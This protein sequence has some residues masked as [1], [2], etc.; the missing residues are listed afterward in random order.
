MQG[1]VG[2]LFQFKIKEAIK[3]VRIEA[4]K[5]YTRYAE[6]P[7]TSQRRW[8]FDME[9]ELLQVAKLLHPVTEGIYPQ[10]QFFSSL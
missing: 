1:F 9:L 8:G 2:R 6:E 10:T 7:K 4:T 5:A 3:A